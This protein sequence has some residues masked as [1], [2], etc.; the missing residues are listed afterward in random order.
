MSITHPRLTGLCTGLAL[1]ACLATSTLGFAPAPSP[2]GST[3]MVAVWDANGAPLEGAVV[4]ATNQADGVKAIEQGSGIYL[5]DGAGTTYAD[6]VKVSLSVQHSV[7][8]TDTS[9]MLLTAVPMARIEL[10]FTGLGEVDSFSPQ[11]TTGPAPGPGDGAPGNDDCANAAAAE[12]GVVASGS[13]LGASVDGVGTCGTA[14]TAPG[15]WYSVTGTGNTMTATTCTA[16]AGYD[17]KLSVF[18]GG[19]DDLNCIGGND[20]NCSGGS[21]GLLSTTSWCSQAGASYL[22]LVHGFSSAT[23]DFELLVSDDGAECTG[24]VAC[25]GSGACCFADGSCEQLTA[26]ACEAAGGS[27]SGD[28]ADCFGAGAPI[29]SYGSAP[30]AAIPDNTPAGLSDSLVIGD[31]ATIGDIDVELFVDHTW[32]GDLI[33]TLTHEDTGTSAVIVDQIGV[34]VISTFGC[35]EDNFAGA[36]LDDEGGDAIEDQCQPDLSSPPNYTPAEALSAFDGEDLAGTWTLNISDNAAADTGSL[37][38]W[39]M[40]VSGAGA[41]TCEPAECFLVIGDGPGTSVFTGADHEFETQVGPE[42]EDSYAVLMTQIPSFVLP[43]MTRR[44]SGASAQVATQGG[45]ALEPWMEDG[46]FAVQVVMWNPN[47]FP[48][49]PEQFTA[50]LDVEILPNGKVKTSSM[51]DALG[52]LTLEAQ[53]DRL[54]D[55]TRVISFPFAIPGF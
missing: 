45:S 50:A 2:L 31:S 54:P 10:V 30:N 32:V 14:N 8:G 47:V 23:G 6:L 27:Y 42:I 41:P 26:A 33:V 4:T 38:S 1:T 35:P 24:A 28:G 16:A 20:D 9:D 48:W 55:G 39:S 25:L 34:P 37:V 46:H 44:G 51:G 12:V 52:G 3:M 36:V 5:L 43:P 49:L 13:T 22:I 21:S 11:A 40:S 18:C 7:W 15:V 17:T 19:C 53:I 29:G